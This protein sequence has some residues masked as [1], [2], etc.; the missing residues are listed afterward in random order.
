M[1]R[2]G[3]RAIV[4]Q[5]V[6]IFIGLAVLFLAAGTLNWVN[7]W[8][9]AALVIIGQSVSWLVL[10]K[11]NP[12]VLNA[13]G[14]LARQGTK[15][16]D[17]I[18]LALYPI[19]SFGNLI[20]VGFD[21]V[22]FHWSYMPAWLCALGIILF[23]PGIVIATWAMSANKFFEWTV[24]IQEDRGHYVCQ[25]GPYG[26]I[27][28]PGYAALILSLMAY[29]FI[30]GS[31]WG[32]AASAALSLIVVVRTALE[33]RTLQKELPGYKEYAS[34]VRYRLLPSVW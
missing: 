1:N 33:D 4:A 19:F 13:R 8:I 34:K 26:V 30:L 2:E 17:R 29:P 24:R 21:A 5:I 22:R 3:A 9:Y 28:H 15:A 27:R 18:W 25:D 11:V 14:G 7:G 31:W 6:L 32:L 10:A 23:I 12:Q 16:F 20:V